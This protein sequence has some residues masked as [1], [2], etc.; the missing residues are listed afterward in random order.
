V[1]NAKPA[2]LGIIDNISMGG[3]TFQNI[4]SKIQLNNAFVLDILLTESR[5]YLADIPF[6]IIS[7]FE[8]P[9]DIPGDPIE[10]RQVRLQ[11]Q[12]LSVNHQAKLIDFILNQGVEIGEIG[13]KE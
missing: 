1:F 3:L 4:D 9:E 10:M 5:L 12:K 8:I 7:D 2:K 11:F 13:V 6:K